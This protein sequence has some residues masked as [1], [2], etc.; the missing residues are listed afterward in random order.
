[1]SLRWL[2]AALPVLLLC[3]CATPPV[4]VS[5]DASLM[6][7]QAARE[8]ALSGHD[9]WTLQGRLF[10]SDGKNTPP[11]VNLTWRQDGESYEF[12]VRAPITGKSFRLTGGPG[13]AL[14]EGLDQGPM[15]GS[16]A[17]ELMSR[18]VGWKVPLRDLRAWAQGV[19]ADSGPADLSFGADRLPSL[20]TQDGWNVEYRE[21][22]DT[23]QPA[24]PKKVFAE[25]LPYHVKL[26][27]ESWTFD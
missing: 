12:T 13:H 23:R 21:W 10:V 22:D 11:T 27:I 18:A 26:S 3:A 19:R 9:R 4:R 17:E 25:R 1:M 20:L 6:T 14:L 2:F 5:G 15:S 8:K 7:A 24:L 16:D